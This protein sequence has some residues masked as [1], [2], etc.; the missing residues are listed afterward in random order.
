ML[1]LI[2]ILII[3]IITIITISIIIIVLL[4]LSLVC[5][6]TYCTV[7]LLDISPPHLL[8]LRISEGVNILLHSQIYPFE[9]VIII[10]MHSRHTTTSTT[11]NSNSNNNTSNND[12]YDNCNHDASI[13]LF[14]RGCSGYFKTVYRNPPIICVSKRRTTLLLYIDI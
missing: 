9:G 6:T 1:I 2:L 14:E 10:A 11:N 5:I 3:I 12:N 13:A 7:S 8:I 4:S